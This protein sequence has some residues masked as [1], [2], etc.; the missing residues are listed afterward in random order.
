MSMSPVQILKICLPTDEDPELSEKLIKSKN[1]DRQLKEDKRDMDNEVKILLLGAGESGKTTILKQMQILHGGG[2]FS[3]EQLERYRQQVFKNIYDGMKACLDI[4]SR[5]QIMFNDRTLFAFVPLFSSYAKLE[6]GKAHQGTYLETLRRLWKD[7]GVRK[8]MCKVDSAVPA[9][10][11]YF[12]PHLD[13]I[14]KPTFVPTNQDILQCREQTIG[15]TEMTFNVSELRY[16]MVDV[17]GQR[18]E[19]K[20]WMHC[21]EHVTSIIFLVAISGYDAPV[22]EDPDTNQLQEALNVFDSIVNSKWFVE[23]AFVLFMNKI[24]LFKEKIAHSSIRQHFPDYP[25]HDTDVQAAQ[26]YFKN[27]FLLLNHSRERVIYTHFTCATDTSLMKVVMGSVT[28][29]I[30]EQNL[31]MLD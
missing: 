30:L 26:T 6:A 7:E 8:A 25:G 2:G 29:T 13:R 15:I 5:D 19:R 27:K 14:F 16:R 9:S 11:H 17:G 12:Y 3:T 28:K 4:M 1:I 20:K 24:D 22:L 10:M 18:S 21:F 31:R 23:T